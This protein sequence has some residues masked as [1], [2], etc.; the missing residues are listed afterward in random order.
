MSTL[1]IT[2]VSV[3]G[4]LFLSSILYISLNWKIKG[5]P[6]LPVSRDRAAVRSDKTSFESV[7]REVTS[8]LLSVISSLTGLTF[9]GTFVV[10]AL[11]VFDVKKLEDF[12]RVVLYVVLGL[13]G[14]A[15]I[16]WLLALQALTTMARPSIGYER[17]FRLY[18][19]VTTLWLVGMIL[20]V[21]SLVLFP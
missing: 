9:T 11:V 16:W 20:I 8:A 13:I 18:V 5:P 2:A 7:K 10:L 21:F 3:I 6:E 4:G 15:A 1:E 14:V 19:Y 17:M 12:E